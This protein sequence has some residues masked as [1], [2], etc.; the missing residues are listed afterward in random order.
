MTRPLIHGNRGVVPASRIVE[1]VAETLTVIKA[2]DKLTWGDIGAAIGKSEDQAAKYADGSAV[3]DMPTFLRACNTWNGRFSNPVLA[4]FNLH[5]AESAAV[6]N[7]S[8]PH[9]LLG[10]TQLSASLQQAML[11]QKITDEEVIDMHSYIE[12]A[13]AL[14]DYLRKRHAEALERRAAERAR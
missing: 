5:I 1:A 12:V 2:E 11:D 10:M 13:G 4:L 9:L 6:T 3:M 7:G 14:V 8:V